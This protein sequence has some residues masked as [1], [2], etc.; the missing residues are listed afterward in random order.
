MSTED[1][2]IIGQPSGFLKDPQRVGLMT[3]RVFD[4]HGPQ[5]TGNGLRKSLFAIVFGMEEPILVRILASFLVG[6]PRPSMRWIGYLL[7][8]ICSY[9]S[10][11]SKCEDSVLMRVFAVTGG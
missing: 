4:F 7:I 6:M 5:Y 8:V 3:I 11:Y 2:S 1:Y 9:P 10:W